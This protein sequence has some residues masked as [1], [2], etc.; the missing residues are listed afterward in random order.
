MRRNMAV[1]LAAVVLAL[2]LGTPT[3]TAYHQDYCS[4]GQTVLHVSNYYVGNSDNECIGYAVSGVCSGGA[5]WNGKGGDD[6]LVSCTAPDTLIGAIGSDTLYGHGSSDFFYDGNNPPGVGDRIVGGAGTGD[7]LYHCPTNG[8][9]DSWTGI[10]V[11]NTNS[12]YC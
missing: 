12:N 7:T 11:V 6:T 9:D 3:A 8:S 2:V 5:V 1:M 4:G 10:E